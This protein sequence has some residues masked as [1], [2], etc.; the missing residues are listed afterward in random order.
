MS[1]NLIKNKRLAKN[2]AFLYARMLLVLLVNLYITRAVLN[3]LGV[4]DYG[5]YNIVAGFVSM[6]A[7]MNTSMSIGIQRFYN[8]EKGKGCEQSQNGVYN[9]ALTIQFLIGVVTLILLETF[10]FWYINNIM[11]VPEDRLFATNCV[12]QF[13]V[14]SLFLVIMQVPYSAAIMA[15]ERMDF[16][17][18]VSIFDVLCKLGIVIAIPYI[19]LDRLIFYGT[20]VALVSLID[21]VC[22]YIYVRRNFKELFFDFC[23]GK[24][25]FLPM[26]SFSIW[27]LFDM[28]AFTMKGQGLNVLLNG[29]FGPVV[30]AAR[31]IAAQIM[32][33]IQGFSSN[34]VTAFRPQLVE[35]YAQGDYQRTSGLM[36]SMSK[37][38][39]S[40]LFILS[41][42]I[43]LEL[44]YILNFWLDGNVP[45]YT[46]VFTRLV[47]IDMLVN[48]LNTPL[49]QVIQAV[50]KLKTYQIVR[51][52][53][54]LLILPISWITLKFGADPTVVF[55]VSILVSV[56]N[57][58]VSMCLLRRVYEYS[59]KS[60]VFNI[61]LPCFLLTVLS[62][63]IPILVKFLIP[64]GGIRLFIISLLSVG[65]CI[66]LFFL[67]MLTNGQRKESIRLVKTKLQL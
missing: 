2:T 41:L 65:I 7:F 55:I 67:L 25:F 24:K 3:S 22:Y 50:G 9:S 46:I 10:G 30:N 59:Y 12:F 33:A 11:V 45:E 47:L 26:F 29:F 36:F 17:A 5:I 58:A 48:S 61:L 4:V 28:F 16:Y 49:S 64:Q 8:Y 27:N 54:I 21:L 37:I 60:Y 35:S 53:V 34:I 14:L 6:F 19:S 66:M 43:I 44:D 15:Y 20:F 39:Y 23:C 52:L 62:L 56:I 51:S 1:D 42:P 63:P 32:A 31:G 57:Q 38:S 18:I 13:S 40:L